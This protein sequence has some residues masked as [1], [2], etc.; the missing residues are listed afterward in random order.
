MAEANRQLQLLADTG[1]VLSGTLG[2]TQQ[3]QQLVELVVPSL[4][5]W[6]WL[7]V[8]DEQ[9]RLDDLA[10]AHRD[11]S[12]RPEL[13]R[14]VRGMV[15]TMT[16]DAGARVVARTGRP[17]IITDVDWG[18]F[19]RV[20]PDAGVRAALSKLDLG[21]GAIVPLVAQG[22]TIGALGLFN[23]PARGPHSPAEVETATE[24]GRRAGL[25]LQHARLYGQQRALADALQRS[26]L[27]DPP[28]SEHCEIVVRYQP[29]AE[30]AE[31]GGDWYDAFLQPG[32]E[33][34]LAIGDVVGHDVRA[35][36]AMGQVRGLLRG[37]GYARG[38]SPAEVL[39]ELDRAVQGFGL[40][41]MATALV[42]R[43]ETQDA[44]R[45]AARETTRLRPGQVLLRWASAGHPPPLVL[46]SD[47]RVTPLDGAPAD[48][49]LG[50][51][52]ES[53]REDR[54]VVL[55]PGDTVLLYTDGLIERRDR[56]IDAGTDEL[57][58]V[59][60]R[61]AGLSLDELCDGVLARMFLPDAEDD[62]ALL[63]VRLT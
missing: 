46:S 36:A 3:I 40:D 44:R 18:H 5:D 62:V 53:R 49:L 63:A 28:H 20:L 41:T 12:R 26:M 31:V 21:A 27:T 58:A 59:L 38:G 48:L 15:A 37:I 32:G 51:A 11:R 9:G 55:G 6:C 35:A 29:A 54:A 7:V 17:V 43:L 10:C 4:A 25:S 24:L 50:V 39:T 8:T 14:Y 45:D 56:D 13:E 1:R 34:V 2:I 60:Q 33:T 19:E 42:A 47:G 30:G 61:C 22:H 23:S 57:I 52:P 16:D